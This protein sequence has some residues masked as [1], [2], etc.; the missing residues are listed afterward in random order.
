M[1]LGCISDTDVQNLYLTEIRCEIW[2]Q[3][4]NLTGNGFIFSDSGHTASVV[5]LA[6]Y[7]EMKVSLRLLHSNVGC[8]EIKKRWVK[9]CSLCCQSA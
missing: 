5:I 3:H 4:T 9:S 6:K 2:T 1:F 8:C 7:K